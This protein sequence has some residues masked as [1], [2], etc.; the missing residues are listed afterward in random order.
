MATLVEEC[1]T[2]EFAMSAAMEINQFAQLVFEVD[3]RNRLV[4]HTSSASEFA[5][6]L[7]IL[8]SRRKANRQPRCNL[9]NEGGCLFRRDKVQITAISPSPATILNAHKDLASQ[10]LTLNDVGR[11]RDLSPNDLSVAVVVESP[12][13]NL[14]LGADLENG[15]AAEHGWNAVL[16]S[17]KIPKDLSHFFKIPH[18]G[19]KGSHHSDVWSAM[20]KAGP[21]SIVTPY[22]ALANPLPTDDD[23]IRIAKNSFEAY[24]TTWQIGR[25]VQQECRDRSRMPSSA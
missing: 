25:A 12:N 13:C 20:V 23:V 10:I 3:E 11:F 21:I 14:L 22:T 8:D 18:H 24:C 15:K 16:A 4:T 17:N 7:R 2:A 9:A 1:V 6:I 5:S 19:S